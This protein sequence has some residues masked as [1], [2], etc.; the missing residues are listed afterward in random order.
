MSP[1]FSEVPAQLAPS[2]FSVDRQ[3]TKRAPA[4]WAFVMLMSRELSACMPMAFVSW[5]QK[6][7]SSL[8]AFSG[9]IRLP[10][11]SWVSYPAAG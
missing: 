6:D 11:R 2:S 10:M 1:F 5:Y 7:G 4:Y 8:S 3:A 9:T